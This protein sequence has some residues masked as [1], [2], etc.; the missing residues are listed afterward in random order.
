MNPNPG[1]NLRWPALAIA[2]AMLIATSVGATYLVLRSASHP[3][4][5]GAGMATARPSGAASSS[6]AVAL[7]SGAPLPDV[8]V[9]LSPD[10]VARAGITVATVGTGRATSGLRLPGVVEPNAYRQV[11]VTPVAGGR[12]T[13]VL[14]ESGERVRRGQTMAQVFSSEVAEAFTRYT[15]VRA[16]L[17]AHERELARTEKLVEIGAASRQELERLHA[18]HTARLADVLSARSRLELLGVPASALDKPAGPEVG[19]SADVSAPIDGVV[20][21]RRANVGLNVDPASKL[22]TVVDLTTVWVVAE[23]YEKDFS[24]VRVGSPATVTTNAYPDLSLQGRVSYIDPQVSADTRTAKLRV[25]VR[26]PGNQLR[27]GMYTDVQVSGIGGTAVPVIPRSAVQTVG[28]RQ[29]V[30][31]ADPKQPG[32]FTEREVRL[33]APVGETIEVLSGVQ[34][35]DSIVAAGSFFVRA[36]RERLGLHAPS[37][38]SAG[39]AQTDERSQ[40]RMNVQTAKVLVGEKGYEPGRVSLRA[41]TPAKIT[42]VRTTDSTC[43]TE[44]LFPS[45]NIKRALPLN[46][47]VVIEFTPAKTGEIAFACGMNMLHG[48]VVVQ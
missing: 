44:V 23:L 13:R 16:D 36:E 27:L 12:V 21:E 45:L 14:V 20:T 30:Y 9:S 4:S 47:P 39:S 32:R 2:A 34:A 35:G 8:V 48:T 19:A 40:A 26:N 18:E 11:V 1:V 15:S 38:P 37:A 28:D 5:E 33:G 41:G 31:L 17:D 29:V 46:E 22:F 3:E 25:E 43:G 6:A 7:P 24:R 42:F 10:A